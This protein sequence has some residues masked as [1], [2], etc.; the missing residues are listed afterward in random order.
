[1]VS[2]PQASLK[3]MLETLASSAGMCV[4]CLPSWNFC[5]S[6]RSRVSFWSLRSWNILFFPKTQY[7]SKKLCVPLEA[8]LMGEVHD[9]AVTRRAQRAWPLHWWRRSKRTLSAFQRITSLE[10]WARARFPALTNLIKSRSWKSGIVL[11]P[12]KSI[13]PRQKR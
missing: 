11:E 8:I 12:A 10:E 7:L 9:D 5:P 4:P 3:E 6:G 13:G 1:M 2:L